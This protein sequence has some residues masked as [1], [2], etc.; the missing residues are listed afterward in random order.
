MPKS[1]IKFV[2]DVPPAFDGRRGR[3]HRI[4]FKFSVKMG[5]A[6]DSYRLVQLG[7]KGLQV[8]VVEQLFKTH[9]E[10]ERDITDLGVMVGAGVRAGLE[11]EEVRKW[12]ESD[13][14]GAVI[15]GE[16]LKLR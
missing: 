13:D 4:D 16:V 2:F 14:G 7:K 10:E 1:T 12:L 8:P 5:N 3:G 15:D 6:R 11:E 9:F